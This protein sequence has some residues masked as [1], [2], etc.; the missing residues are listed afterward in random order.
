[1]IYFNNID[2]IELLKYSQ[3]VE[4]LD[5]IK[6]CPDEKKTTINMDEVYSALDALLNYE[7]HSN[8]YYQYR[9]IH[10][11]YLSS[12][13]VSLIN[14][15]KKYNYYLKRENNHITTTGKKVYVVPHVLTISVLDN[16]EIYQIFMDK[17]YT[18]KNGLH[19]NVHDYNQEEI[20]NW[21]ESISKSVHLIY[22]NMK[23]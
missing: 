17:I 15:Y 1:M 22:K 12:F 23:L 5:I 20:N 19:K 6:S 14:D 3:D 13:L 21:A 11:S 18:I 9:H 2:L 16:P 10:L 7:K 8:Q 4:I